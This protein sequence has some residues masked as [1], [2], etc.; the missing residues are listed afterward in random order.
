MK[1]SVAVLI[2]IA[3]LL[4]LS[5]FAIN[6]LAISGVVFTFLGNK[7]GGFG[8]MPKFQGSDKKPE[9]ESENDNEKD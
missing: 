3:A 4:L 1:Y 5:S 9:N 8:A 2:V 7:T 6:I